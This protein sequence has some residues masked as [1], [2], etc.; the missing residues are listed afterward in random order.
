MGGKHA[1]NIVNHLDGDVPWATPF[2]FIRPLAALSKVHSV[3][4]KRKTADGAQTLATLFKIV[5]D[6]VGHV[7]KRNCASRYE[8]MV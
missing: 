2:E 4:M 6:V 7:W 8:P 1:Q 5:A 3:E